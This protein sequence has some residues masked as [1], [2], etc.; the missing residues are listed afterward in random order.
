M[1][2]SGTELDDTVWR[3]ASAPPHVGQ[4]GCSLS[5][6]SGVS[7]NGPMLNRSI[8][9]LTRRDHTPTRIR[10]AYEYARSP[11]TATL[12]RDRSDDAVAAVGNCR[13]MSPRP[14][15]P[16]PTLVTGGQLS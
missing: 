16:G 9:V 8:G 12:S 4:A 3:C 7:L 5:E 1:N 14:N 6:R 11:A 10:G 2:R 13:R 15:D